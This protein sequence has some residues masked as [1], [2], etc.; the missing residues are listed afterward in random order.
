M[1]DILHYFPDSEL[2]EFLSRIRSVLAIGGR[3]VI[4]TTIPGH[5]FRLF[6]FVEEWKLKFRGA[7]YYFR[8]PEQIKGILE[9]ADFK[10]EMIE[11]SAPGREETWFIASRLK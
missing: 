11:P 7:D 3:L 2:R 4:R 5:G 6:R 1:L 10:M 9:G 8:N